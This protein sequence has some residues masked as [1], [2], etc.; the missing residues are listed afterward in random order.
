MKRSEKKLNLH[1]QTIA[2]LTSLQLSRAAGGYLIVTIIEDTCVRTD[3]ACPSD[4][5]SG[6]NGC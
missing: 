6:C 5:L 2:E 3:R 4:A 1:R